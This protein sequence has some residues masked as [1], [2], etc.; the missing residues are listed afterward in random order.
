MLIHIMGYHIFY[1]TLGQYVY[2]ILRAVF[3]FIISAFFS[4]LCVSQLCL[5]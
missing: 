3:V 5:V 1:I 4:L 2:A